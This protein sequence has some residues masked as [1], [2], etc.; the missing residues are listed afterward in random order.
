MKYNSRIFVNGRR[1][2]GKGEQVR[3]Y[4]YKLVHAGGD[5]LRAALPHRERRRGVSHK[6]VRALL[7]SVELFAP[8]GLLLSPSILL[9]APLGLLPAPSIL[10]LAARCQQTLECCQLF[11]ER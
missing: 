5:E 2:G 6:L 11:G 8:L 10:L 7:H 9:L 1:V 3:V 4:D